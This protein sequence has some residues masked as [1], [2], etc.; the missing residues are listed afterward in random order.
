MRFAHLGAPDDS[1]ARL[2]V[3]VD[4][5]AVFADDL[6]EDAPR[7]LQDLIE[8][9]LD[10]T[11]I[12]EN[13]SKDAVG[14]PDLWHP[15]SKLRHASAVLRPPVI[16]A[17]GANYAAHSAELALKVEKAATVFSLWP[18]SLTAHESTTTW[19][20]ELSDEV[21]Y[22]AELGVII[23]RPAR[24]VRVA[25][26]LDYVFGYTVVNDITARNLQFSEAQWSRC[27]SFDGFTPTGPVVVTADQI[28]DP[29]DLWLATT[30][31][32]RLLQDA[33][34]SGMVRSVAELIAF[35]S[36]STTLQPGTLIS[37]GSPGG[38]GYSRTPPIFLRDRSKVTV[39]C[40]G[41]GSLTTY[42]RVV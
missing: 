32:G 31:D 40:S 3:V 7:D 13:A 4:D 34:T 12:L 5:K 42:C 23:G 36:R 21:D 29:Q 33:S 24:N 10:L 35:L 8:R 26:A 30:V 20:A 37:T 27:K 15:V 41:I 17:I 19:P 16:L 1:G 22:E 18:N 25:D 11:G 9:G 38:A 14:R 2:A 28:P 6:I 39:S